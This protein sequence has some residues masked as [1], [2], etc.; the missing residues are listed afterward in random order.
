MDDAPGRRVKPF[1]PPD[2]A[3]GFRSA[4]QEMTE[5]FLRAAEQY[6]AL[7]FAQVFVLHRDAFDPPEYPDVLG[8][9]TLSMARLPVSDVPAALLP[10][11]IE[12]SGGPLQLPAALLGRMARHVDVPAS[13]KLGA[14][15]ICD[16]IRRLLKLRDEIG[17]FCLLLD[18][19]NEGLV[20]YYSRLGFE[21]IKRK[22]SPQKMMLPMGTA[23]DLLAP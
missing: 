4:D 6:Q 9:Y 23:L 16:A 2:L 21:T 22:Q 1:C 18:A 8:Y 19:L 13:E 11:C 3:L 7:G 12:T 5:F 14:W 17:C 15:L 20:S 10:T